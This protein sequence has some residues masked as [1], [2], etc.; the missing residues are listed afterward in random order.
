MD[1]V[2]S[3]SFIEEYGND[4]EKARLRHI[5]YESETE[6]DIID[7]FTG[8]QNGDGGFPCGLV[9]RNPSSIEKTHIALWWLDELGTQ[10]SPLVDQAM[11]FIVKK[12]SADGSWDE[13]PSL[14]SYGLPLWIIPGDLVTRLYLTAYSAFWLGVSGRKEHP[15]FQNALGFLL[16]YHEDTGEFFG[17]LHTSWLATSA[18]IM[19]GDQYSDTAKRGLYALMEKPLS[20]FEASQIAWL[21]NCLGSAGVSKGHPVATHFLIGL[22][23]RRRSD[24]SWVSEDGDSHAVDATIE[25][26]RAFKRFGLLRPKPPPSTPGYGRSY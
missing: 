3:K 4:L 21:L 13:D 23:Q 19:A 20:E 2:K 5:L 12:Q 22:R 18:F 1:I 24:G 26:L 15:S 8:Q 9:K 17:Y 14:T 6:P 25:A 16:E 10:R 11:E 7:F